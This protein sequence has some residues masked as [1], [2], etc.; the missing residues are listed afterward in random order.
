MFLEVVNSIDGAEIIAF[1][2]SR[3]DISSISLGAIALVAWRIYRF[4]IVP[5]MYPD[6][7]KELPY[8]IPG[9]S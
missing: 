3:P 9:K 2:K 7:P 4:T 8:W 5:M 1:A 6:D